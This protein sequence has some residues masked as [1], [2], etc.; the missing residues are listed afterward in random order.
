M[1]NLTTRKG[2]KFMVDFG[3]VPLPDDLIKQLLEAIQQL[4]LGT[5]AKTDFKGDIHIGAQLPPETYGMILGG[6]G[7]EGGE[8]GES[9]MASARELIFPTKLAASK[10]A[11]VRAIRLSRVKYDIRYEQLDER[12]QTIIG[13]VLH[14]IVDEGKRVTG[15]TLT[16]MGSDKGTL[17]SADRSALGL[18]V[19][20]LSQ[21]ARSGLEGGA[22]GGE[23]TV[24]YD[25][26]GV[27]ATGLSCGLASI[28]GGTDILDDVACATGIVS[29][30][31]GG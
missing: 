27:I 4:A 24:V 22:T 7:G 31:N 2:A 14:P 12:N 20:E 25:W 3:P 6:P 9:V 18:I 30:V 5:V 26:W 29:V 28:S 8:G 10:A 21:F 13:F 15:A 17:G 16:R 11:G 19:D 23:G 1:K